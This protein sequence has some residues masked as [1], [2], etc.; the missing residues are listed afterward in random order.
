MSDGLINQYT[1]ELF[2]LSLEMDL[3]TYKSQLNAMCPGTPLADSGFNPTPEVMGC[4][5]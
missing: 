2:Y 3:D 5:D 1:D 4:D